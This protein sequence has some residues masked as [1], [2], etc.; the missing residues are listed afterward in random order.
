MRRHHAFAL[1]VLV[2]ACGVGEATGTD[3][4]PT[5]QEPIS[6]NEVD[7]RQTLHQLVDG[8]ELEVPGAILLRVGGESVAVGVDGE[9]DPVSADTPFE[10]ASVVKSVVATGVMQLVEQGTLDLDS[11]VAGYVD[12]PVAGGISLRE[13]L[14]HRSG[15]RDLTAHF[16]V[17][18]TPDTLGL[19]RQV[20]ATT[21]G[22]LDSPDYSNTN[23]LLLGELIRQVTG[24]D[25]GAFLHGSIFEPAGMESTYF[26]DS[27]DG[28]DPFWPSAQRDA[29]PVSP[30][31]CDDL[32]LTVGTEGRTFVTTVGDLARFVDALWSG[33]L[34]GAE[35]LEAMVPTPG[36][37][38]LGLWLETNDDF[39]GALLIGHYGARVG[40]AYAYR[41]PNSGVTVTAYEFGTTD[42]I[43]DLVWEASQ[44]AP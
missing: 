40:S 44:P 38:G 36:Q 41:D 3:A 4:P 1:A 16:D 11:D 35:T 33:G 29:G 43:E 15:F 31:T 10:A 24:Q 20:V 25:V 32:D 9:G 14:A 21:N 5:V 22:P 6:S 42:G 27:Q 13:V 19:M 17:C 26:W 39:P 7:S 23:Y 37:A 12:F 28:P 34:V 2:G 18:P 30:F 8:V